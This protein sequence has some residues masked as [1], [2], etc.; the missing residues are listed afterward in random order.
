VMNAFNE[1][2]KVHI[3]LCRS[4]NNLFPFF[5]EFGKPP[6][7]APP[8]VRLTRWT[9]DLTSNSEEFASRTLADFIGEFPR[10][11]DRYQ[12]RPYRHGWLL[13]FGGSRN[14]LGHVDLEQGATEVWEA[15]P[16]VPL[17]EPC[18]V[19]RSPGAAEGDGWILQ[20]ATDSRTMLTELNLFE[21]T[22]IAK[23][24]IATVK[25]PFRMKPALHGSWADGS[26]V[27]PF[28]EGRA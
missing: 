14:S 16:E 11:D 7:F 21:A 5:P 3:D 23:G 25:L 13:G 10:N 19:P 2:T 24:P 12:S 20:A 15:P 18:F 27:K 4:S 1:G 9:A 26:L 8:D 17:Q 28:T 22:N 6:A